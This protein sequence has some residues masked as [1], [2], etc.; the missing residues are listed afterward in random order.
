MKTKLF[1]L[2]AIVLFACSTAKAYDAEIDGI[3]YNF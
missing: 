1:L 3:Y 2:M